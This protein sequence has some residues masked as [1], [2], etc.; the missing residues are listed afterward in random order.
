MWNTLFREK[1]SEE[2]SARS[3]LC[4]MVIQIHVR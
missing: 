4:E 2:M 1:L 3:R